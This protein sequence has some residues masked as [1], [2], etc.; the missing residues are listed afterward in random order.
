MSVSINNIILDTKTLSV[1]N[2]SRSLIDMFHFTGGETGK[3][4]LF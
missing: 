3:D 4:S 1:K 2:Q